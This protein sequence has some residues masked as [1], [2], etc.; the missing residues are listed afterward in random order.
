MNRRVVNRERQ[1]AERSADAGEKPS[2]VEG[3]TPSAPA[4]L[5]RKQAA[6]IGAFT[7]IACGPFEDIHE[8]VDGLPGFKGITT[9]GFA[10]AAQ[11]IKE[12]AR[13]DF[14]ALCADKSR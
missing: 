13:A 9:I 8:Y 11:S 1:S 12:A 2:A 14:L 5:T 10:V 6:I 4:K 3:S 7:G